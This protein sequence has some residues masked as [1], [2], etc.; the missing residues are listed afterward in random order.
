MATANIDRLRREIEALGAQEREELL[1]LLLGP[2]PERGRAHSEED[3]EREFQERLLR[4]GALRSIPA[5]LA[6][7][8]YEPVAVTGRPVSETLVD[9]REPR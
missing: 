1:A 3:R 4:E 8:D 5:G 6:F 9:D 2:G 7:E